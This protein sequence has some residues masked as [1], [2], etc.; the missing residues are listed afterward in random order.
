MF[1]NGISSKP[2]FQ[3]A[4]SWIRRFS[5]QAFRETVKVSDEVR[6]AISENI[7]VVA[8]ESTIITHG[9][10]YPENIEMAKEVERLIRLNGAIPASIGFVKGVPTVGLNE[11]DI[12]LLGLPDIYNV[13]I[14][15]R[16]FAN[17]L[18]R[19]LTGGTTIAGTMI[20]AN[21]AGVDVFA[22]GGLG[23]VSRPCMDTCRCQC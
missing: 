16:D 22:T 20:L 4:Q 17:V 5:G 11:S 10:P 14:T 1:S 15:R 8:L 6:Q 23:G 21:M 18:T 12:E 19:K 2:C 3:H 7:P 13:K 9:L